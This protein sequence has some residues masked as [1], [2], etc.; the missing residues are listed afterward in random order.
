MVIKRIS[1]NIMVLGSAEIISKIFLF[2]LMVYAARLLGVVSFGKF[3]FALAFSMLTII[4]SD[5]GINTLLIREISRKKYLANKYFINAFIG[6]LFLSAITFIMVILFLNI[7]N[8]PNDT[9]MVVYMIWFF[10]TLSSFTDLLYSIF[11]AFERMVYDAFL[12]ILRMSLLTVIG[13]YVLFQGYG[14]FIFSLVFILVEAIVFLA[15]LLIGTTK[16]IKIELK[17]VNISFIK[18][19]VKRAFPFGLA[20]IFGS[21]YFYI[22][23]IMLSKM[24]GPEEVAVYSVAYNLVLALLFIPAV[25][26]NAVYPVFSRYFKISKQKLIFM[27]KKSFKYLYIIGIPIS[28]GL[29]LLSKEIINFFYGKQYLD[30]IIALQI[31]SWFVFLKF[32]N[33][34]NG[35]TL[36][37]IDKQKKR[38]LSQGSTALFNIILNLILIPRLGFIGAAISTLITE[39]FLFIIYYSFVSR[40]FYRLN[41]IPILIKPLIAS[42]AMAAFLL[43]TDIN[44]FISIAIASIIY[45][46]VLVLIK[47]FEKDDL[48]IMWAIIKNEKI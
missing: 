20:I 14:L 21:I 8:Y 1:R 34:L 12:K 47:A 25:Y 29:F 19:L 23:S 18:N 39:I 35:I 36:F 32:L 16:F 42:T 3:T 4:L 37:A 5:L 46:T 40:F 13:L 27:H 17:A 24:K 45:L 30:S 6:K 9:K 44:L 31:I 48:K 15:A 28:F 11:R 33:F 7:L 43:F 26:I 41:F 10:T 38:M 22:D 2:I